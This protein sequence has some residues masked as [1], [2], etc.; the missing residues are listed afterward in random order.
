M[1]VCSLVKVTH[2]T[3]SRRTVRGSMSVSGNKVCVCYHL[4]IC[5]TTKRVFVLHIISE[6]AH[7]YFHIK[8][9]EDIQV[10][11]VNMS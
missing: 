11:G 10:F 3:R 4:C 8:E 6:I 5:H 2:S 9:I 1:P 7:C